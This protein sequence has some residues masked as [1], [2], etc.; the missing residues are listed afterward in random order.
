[1]TKQPRRIDYGTCILVVLVGLLVALALTD[2]ALSQDVPRIRVC[3]SLLRA[4][5]VSPFCTDLG[6]PPTIETLPFVAE[7]LGPGAEGI[8][9]PVMPGEHDQPWNLQDAAQW[10]AWIVV[11]YLQYRTKVDVDYIG[12]KA[13]GR[14]VWKRWYHWFLFILKPFRKKG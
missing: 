14:D 11:L 12:A 9:I 5:G 7:P 8:Y 2:V 4:D 6:D 10:I 3:D 1:M 13:A